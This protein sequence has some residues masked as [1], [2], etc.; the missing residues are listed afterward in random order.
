MLQNISCL[1]ISKF[2]IKH[3]S[4]GLGF[5]KTALVVSEYEV[6]CDV[7]TLGQFIW[8]CSCLVIS[9]SLYIRYNSFMDMRS[10]KFSVSPDGWAGQRCSPGRKECSAN[11]ERLGVNENSKKRKG[12]GKEGCDSPHWAGPGCRQQLVCSQTEQT[13][14][15]VHS[16]G[17]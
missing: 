7:A 15:W 10:I 12:K 14:T 17:T 3:E 1:E 13:Q 11:W 16:G 9:L 4:E 5:A 6:L 2:Y 8:I